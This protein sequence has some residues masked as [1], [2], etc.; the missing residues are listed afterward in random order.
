MFGGSNSGSS[1]SGGSVSDPS[2]LFDVPGIFATNGTGAASIVSDTAV[3]VLSELQTGFYE[4]GVWTGPRVRVPSFASFPGSLRIYARLSVGSGD[5]T[6]FAYFGIISEVNNYFRGLRIRLDNGAVQTRDIGALTNPGTLPLDGT[7]WVAYDRTGATSN[8]YFG[9]GT[10]TTPPDNWTWGYSVGDTAQ[11]YNEV[12]MALGKNN[13]GVIG[14]V[15]WAD[16]YYEN[17]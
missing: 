14:T 1:S 13:P 12:A 3:L 9:T 16:A 10:T 17:L 5:N 4:G 15:T 8:W 7:G 6:S 2:S 11:P